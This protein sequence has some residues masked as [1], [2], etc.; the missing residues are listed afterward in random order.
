MFWTDTSVA[1]VF[2]KPMHPGKVRNRTQLIERSVLIVF[3]LYA[4]VVALFL[5]RCYL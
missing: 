4:S 2:N 5:K 3:V 1:V